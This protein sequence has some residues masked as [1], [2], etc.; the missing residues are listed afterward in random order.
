MYLK[1]HENFTKNDLLNEKS[2]DFEN[3][4]VYF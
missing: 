4:T 3:W 2:V 1:K